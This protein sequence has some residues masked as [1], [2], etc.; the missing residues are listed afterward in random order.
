MALGPIFKNEKN[1]IKLIYDFFFRIL[2]RYGVIQLLQYVP[3]VE[4]YQFSNFQK[5]R[6][7]AWLNIEP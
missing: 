2:P 3:W 4:N 7:W 1:N 5:F 6:K